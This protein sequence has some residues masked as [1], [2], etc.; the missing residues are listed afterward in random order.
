MIDESQRYLKFNDFGHEKDLGGLWFQ[1]KQQRKSIVW[2]DEVWFVD[3]VDPI[4][5]EPRRG[6]CHMSMLLADGADT[7]TQQMKAAEAALHQIFSN[8]LPSARLI[9]QLFIVW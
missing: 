6:I 5:S 7:N 9:P 4:E 1:S 2:F 8:F 3:L